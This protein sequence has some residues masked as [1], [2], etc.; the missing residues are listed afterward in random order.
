MNKKELP[1]S[2]YIIDKN[3]EKRYCENGFKNHDGT[4]CGDKPEWKYQQELEKAKNK[5]A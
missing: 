1:C 2:A 3:R 4:C 5:T